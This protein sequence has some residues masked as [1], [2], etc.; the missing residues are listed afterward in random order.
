MGNRPSDG[1]ESIGH[2]K[3][4]REGVHLQAEVS[5]ANHGGF[6]QMKWPFAPEL[7]LE[8]FEGVGVEC[9]LQGASEFEALLKSQQLWM[10]WQSYRI[11][12]RANSDWQTVYFPFAAFK[13]YRTQTLL[14]PQRLSHFSLLMAQEGKQVLSV[15]QL[16]LYR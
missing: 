11:S 9:R 1:G 2:F 10:P 16:T 14:N 12:V 13:P 3:A 6:V 8:Q 5:K 4:D 7:R 15:R